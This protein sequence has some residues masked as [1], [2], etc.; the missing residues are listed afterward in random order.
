LTGG[1]E[2]SMKLRMYHYFFV[3][4]N[5]SD[6]QRSLTFRAERMELLINDGFDYNKAMN[7][8]LRLWSKCVQGLLL[9]LSDMKSYLFSL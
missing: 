2:D 6:V 9:P 8:P 3:S 5:F 1:K 4:W 7:N